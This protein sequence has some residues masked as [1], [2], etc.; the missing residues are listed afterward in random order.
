MVSVVLDTPRTAK[1]HGP[2]GGAASGVCGERGGVAVCAPRMVALR[3]ELGR[4]HCHHA[5]LRQLHG[6]F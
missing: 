3:S 6:Q 2:T 4:L 1:A 5:Q